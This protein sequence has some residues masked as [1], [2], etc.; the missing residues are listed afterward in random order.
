MENKLKNIIHNLDESLKDKKF[1][2]AV[3][4]GADSVALAHLFK[5]FQYRFII[6][7]CN[8]NLRG[9]ESN[10]DEKFVQI[11]GKNLQ[12]PTYIKHFN[13]HQEAKK[14]TESI[15]MI[16]RRLRYNWFKELKESNQCDYIVTAHHLDDRIEGFFLNLFRGT[17]INGMAPIPYFN[18]DL[19]RPLIDFSKTDILNYLSQNSIKY[20]DDQSNF[21]NKYERNKVRLELIPSIEKNFPEFRSKFKQTFKQVEEEKKLLNELELEFFKT[22]LNIHKNSWTINCKQLDL[23]TKFHWLIQ[24]FNGQPSQ[25]K[26][27]KK[28]KNSQTGKHIYIDQYSFYKKDDLIEIVETAIESIYF[29]ID[30][31]VFENQHVYVSDTSD[32]PSIFEKNTLYLNRN[33]IKLPLT[34]RQWKKGDRLIPLGMKGS[35]LVS[36]YLTDRKITGI[37]RS[38]TLVLI[39]D[40]NII[41]ILGHTCSELVKVSDKNTNLL[42]IKLKE[43]N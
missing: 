38:Q 31:C 5:K 9:N 42:T 40:N 36:D 12:I 34:V 25:I 41:G 11:L 30:Q 29:H 1:L 13:T 37:E 43:K 18:E 17:G 26:E 14:T 22:N 2:L 35:K 24:R 15:Q 20:R 7:H 32:Y 23:D 3:S 10:L 6:A 19:F 28:L 21:D 4:G 27:L 33:Q 8:F 16:A 39:S